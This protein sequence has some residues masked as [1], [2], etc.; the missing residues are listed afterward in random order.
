MPI[1]NRARQYFDYQLRDVPSYDNPYDSYLEKRKKLEQELDKL[2][3]QDDLERDRIA[4]EYL[5]RAPSTE[6]GYGTRFLDALASGGDQFQM[7]IGAMGEALGDKIGMAPLE[8]AGRKL[9]ERNRQEMSYAPKFVDTPEE[10]S[11]KGFLRNLDDLSLQAVES[12]VG[13]SPA[14]LPPLVGAA[15]GGPLGVGVGIGG[16]LLGNAALEGGSTFSDYRN[17]LIQRGYSERDAERLA[18]EARDEVFTEN[19][20]DPELLTYGAAQGLVG[21]MAKGLGVLGTGAIQAGTGGLQ[22]GRQYE[23]TETATGNPMDQF[24]GRFSTPEGRNAMAVGMV[25]EMPMVAAEYGAAKYQ[26]RFDPRVDADATA[27]IQEAKGRAQQSVNE[28]EAIR[29]QQ[30]LEREQFLKEQRAAE[31]ERRKEEKEK[32]KQIQ[33]QRIDEERLRQEQ[34]KTDKA[35]LQ[36]LKDL[37][38]DGQT[39]T[40]LPDD[41]SADFVEPMTADQIMLQEYE[42]RQQ[43]EQEATQ[44]PTPESAPPPAP[45]PAPMEPEVFAE[46]APEPVPEPEPTF[47]DEL[48]QLDQLEEEQQQQQPELEQEPAVEEQV[49]PA[50]LEAAAAAKEQEIRQRIIDEIKS[51]AELGDKQPKGLPMGSANRLQNPVRVLQQIAGDE[52]VE[53]QLS[54]EQLR[55]L[56]QTLSSERRKEVVNEAIKEVLQ[57]QPAS[58]VDISQGVDL[59][60]PEIQESTMTPPAQ[61]ETTQ[62]DVITTPEE[63]TL[64]TEVAGQDLVQDQT[65]PVVEETA[66][67]PERLPAETSSNLSSE[68]QAI[69]DLER[70][71]EE[72]GTE[73]EQAGERHKA[74]VEKGKKNGKFN[75]DNLT[76]EENAERKRLYDLRVAFNKLD[77]QIGE[78]YK[79]YQ[80]EVDRL[81]QEVGNAVEALPLADRQRFN[82]LFRKEVNRQ[83]LNPDDEISQLRLAQQLLQQLREGGLATREEIAN[84]KLETETVDTASL[85]EF[86]SIYDEESGPSAEDLAALE[87][88]GLSETAETDTQLE[89]ARLIAEQG[90]DIEQD[91]GAAALR[92][93]GGTNEVGFD[94]GG[95]YDPNAQEFNIRDEE[96]TIDGNPRR[97]DFGRGLRFSYSATSRPTNAA[98]PST[99]LTARQVKAAMEGVKSV[100]KKLDPNGDKVTVVA[101]KDEAVAKLREMGRKKDAD[102]LAKR[103]DDVMEEGFV[104]PGTG[105][106]FLVAD[107]IEGGNLREAVDRMVEVTFHEA[108]GHAGLRGLMGDNFG[109]FV[110]NFGVKNG[111]KIDAW[112]NTED[113][114]VYSD[115]D[116]TTQIE[117][118]IARNFAEKGVQNVG[119]VEGLAQDVLQSLGMRKYSETALKRAMIKVQDSYVG[120]DGDIVDGTRGQVEEDEEL[121]NVETVESPLVAAFQRWFGDSKVLDESGNPRVVYHGTGGGEIVSFDPSKR[122]SFTKAASAKKGFFFA[123]NP[124]TARL[125]F[126]QN[127]IT[128]NRTNGYYLKME[129]PLVYDQK[130]GPRKKLYNDIIK[131]AI[132]K[133]HDG[134]I[135]KNTFDGRRE[136]GRGPQDDIFVVFDN[137]QIK[138]VDN[139]GTFNPDDERVKYSRR[140]ASGADVQG[141]PSYDENL[142]AADTSEEAV[143][144]WKDAN[145]GKYLE[146]PSPELIAAAKEYSEGNYKTEAEMLA[147]QQ[148]Y[149][150][151]VKKYDP[152]KPLKSVPPIRPW[153]DHANA[154]ISS[155][156][157]G[158]K[159]LLGLTKFIA[160]G[161]RVGL[162]LDIPSY[163]DFG[164]Y[165]PTVHDKNGSPIGYGKAAKITDVTFGADNIAKKALR[166]AVDEGPKNPFAKMNGAFVNEDPNALYEQA[167]EIM[168]NPIG[169]ATY[170]DAD[171]NTWTQVGYK[172]HRHSWFYDKT[173]GMPVDTAEEVIQ[174]GALVLAKNAVRGKPTDQKYLTKA[175]EDGGVLFSR[176]QRNIFNKPVPNSPSFVLPEDTKVERAIYNLVDKQ[177]DTK[178]VIDAIEKNIGALKD[179]FNTRELET[180]FHGRVTEGTLDF[181]ENKMRPILKGMQ[182]KKISTEE[183]GYYLH[184]RGAE[185]R[186]IEMA[187]RNKKDPKI[188]QAMLEGGSGMKTTVARKYLSSLSSQKAADFDELAQQVYDITQATRDLLVSEGLETQGTI[189]AWFRAYGREYVPLMRELSDFEAITQGAGEGQGMSVS[190]PASKGATGSTEEN[191]DHGKILA[192]VFSQYERTLVRAEKN[193][194]AKSLYALAVQ[195][196]NPSF[197]RPIDPKGVKEVGKAINALK[198]LGVN[199]LDAQNIFAQPTRRRFD[200]KQRG[201]VIEEVSQGL[202]ANNVLVARI[203]GEDKLL[204][205]NA[206]DDRAT[207]MVS[208]LKNLDTETMG[209][210]A[211]LHRYITRWSTLT[212]TAYSL[213][214]GITNFTRDVQGAMFNL[215]N[216]AI[217]GEQAKVL[218]E[219][220]PALK[221]IYSQ[222]RNIDGGKNIYSQLWEEFR[223]A[224]GKTGYREMYNYGDARQE[225]IVD[226]LKKMSE[227]KYNPKKPLR[228]VAKWVTDYNDALENAVRL[229]AYKTA[230]D[231]GL[232]VQKA[233]VLAKNLTVNFNRKGAKAPGIGAYYAFFNAAVQGTARM[234]EMLGAG[235]DQQS[236]NPYKRLLG[237]RGRQIIQGGL[238]VG[239]MQAIMMEMADYPDEEPPYFVRERN[240]IIPLD[241]VNN[242]GIP[243]DLDKKY[244]SIPM[245][246]GLHVI[247]NIGRTI[248]ENVLKGE[249]P[250]AEKVW[251]LTVSIFDAFNPLGSGGSFL[252]TILPTSVDPIAAIGQNMDWTGRRIYQEDIDSTKPTPGYTRA[253]EGA[254]AL[255][256][257]IARFINLMSG[258]TDFKKGV[259]SPT[260]DQLEYVGGQVTGGVG[261]EIGKLIQT[262]ETGFGT[263]EE[264]PPYK[265]PLGGRFY[266]N[267][268]SSAA[269]SNQFFTNITRMNEHQAEYEGLMKSG[270]TREAQRYLR[271]NPEANLYVLSGKYE[272]SVRKLRKQ[273]REMKERDLPRQQ[274]ETVENLI[275]YQM[276]A[277]NKMVKKYE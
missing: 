108:L 155:K 237:K 6:A 83:A 33:Q 65:D 261:R 178:R 149:L 8:I 208:A 50:E 222:I 167:V 102:D 132:R 89:L 38:D 35:R 230:I 18:R 235:R 39:D 162:R 24:T 232:S 163:K 140:Q 100:L 215:T 91:R 57:R 103:G 77:N 81:E 272:N 151:A 117:E 86:A 142:A 27:V 26:Q 192:N 196:K 44:E 179:E 154:L 211:N 252:Q 72:M 113:G 263:L 134:V 34:I 147:A 20:T 153:S 7:N 248:M 85:E 88:E 183:L 193:K 74:L 225:Q 257:E 17:E 70:Q 185:R 177:I 94:E 2:G 40:N 84:A 242:T 129:N 175:F 128:R 273:R 270:R 71:Q 247:P 174:V 16:G 161:V 266:G 54:F 274:I 258:G 214:F 216:T 96:Y 246:L 131:D 109:K 45:P 52:V 188:Q 238:M 171:G 221:G 186:N 66:P 11:Q 233:A 244:I 37:S 12:L 114:S 64:S 195:N 143:T 194:V 87:A 104:L 4:A 253:N 21:P 265:I 59:R 29:K 168:N 212:N 249:L 141:E 219:T 15:I 172:P 240:I 118:Y 275:R 97:L 241:W 245:P 63:D 234:T 218:K 205:F 47:S 60:E 23:V 107:Q 267:I 187:K 53:T 112:L 144:A 138:R 156:L 95:L 69:L 92:E 145:K 126:D 30:I 206:N 93:S 200:F 76:P 173:D 75:K 250:D 1:N 220:L 251:R 259:L 68:F 125:Y 157:K 269:V 256:T 136:A 254:S 148:K 43:A 152:I 210:V 19:L 228:W 159:G 36:A 120:N 106:I 243:L 116:R 115:D 119:F 49:D 55:L 229:A 255:A 73:A 236:K 262:V 201:E 14:M 51:R 170:R 42:A 10:Q 3:V 190:G 130:G 239:A 202:R 99:K 181:L 182:E 184:A 78:A 165:T 203:N 110:K 226:E 127:K 158:N 13:S 122:G 191:V 213:P 150:A 41:G 31:N 199:P 22:E 101:N 32:L 166:V 79:P 209:L 198:A 5:G 139:K 56:D 80:A 276:E 98:G 137:K 58:S 223:K 164:V 124:K 62:E 180:L 231:K 176:R 121:R 169:E 271:E 105:Q 28:S 135:I 48:D 224:G 217:A 61:M 67:L 189:N 227:G 204:V 90:S 160:D 268:G 82:G 123:G 111:K 133:G 207:R 197:W 9:A 264:L 277:L 46:P 25:A 146:D 260:P